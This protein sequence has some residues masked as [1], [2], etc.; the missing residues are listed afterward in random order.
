[1]SATTATPPT[2]LPSLPSLPSTTPMTPPPP[3]YTPTTR[4]PLPQPSTNLPYT[5]NAN[6]TYNPYNP[7]AGDDSDAEDDDTNLVINASTQI[8]GSGNVVAMPLIDA[9]RISAALFSVLK[10]QG[11][12]RRGTVNVQI[13]CGV[14]IVGERNVVG[15]QGLGLRPKATAA[16]PAAAPEPQKDGEREGERVEEVRSGAGMKRKADDDITPPAPKVVKV[17]SA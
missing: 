3:A 1:M 16:T 5:A 14:T 4:P 13:H 9:P 11:T 15:L 7:F 6:F 2:S 10:T 17:E 8:R 12:G